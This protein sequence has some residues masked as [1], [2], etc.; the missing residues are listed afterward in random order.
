[1][2]LFLL[3]VLIFPILGGLMSQ[4]SKSP[5]TGGLR[6]QTLSLFWRP[7]VPSQGAVRVYF[8]GGSRGDFIPSRL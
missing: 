3:S 6:E 5:W 4:C 2:G 7:E 1:M 8:S